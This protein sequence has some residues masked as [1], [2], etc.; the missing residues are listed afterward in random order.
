VLYFVIL[1]LKLYFY[2][3]IRDNFLYFLILV[4]KNYFIFLN[5]TIANASKHICLW[6]MCV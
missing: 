1:K 3:K 4:K 2:E 5:Y 6:Q